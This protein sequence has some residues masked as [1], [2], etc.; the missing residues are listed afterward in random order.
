MRLKEATKE[1]KRTGKK[2]KVTEAERTAEVK[3]SVTI[4][5][6]LDVLNKI[7][8]EGEQKA[9]PYQTLINSI[10]KQHTDGMLSLEDRLAAIE[11][12]LFRGA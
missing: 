11:K 10:L 5:L 7:K 1:A 12:K 3:V 4:R 8:A 2:Q 6:D 9:I